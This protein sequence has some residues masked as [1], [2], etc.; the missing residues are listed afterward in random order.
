MQE[1]REGQLQE[2]QFPGADL[3]I[4][5]VLGIAQPGEFK[6]GF[7]S[8]PKALRPPRLLEIGDGFHIQVQIIRIENAL[9]Q[10]R[11]G[12]VR[13]AVVDGVQRIQGDEAGVRVVRDPVDHAVQ[14]AQVAAAPVVRGSDAVERQRDARGLAPVGQRGMRISACGRHDEAGF[15]PQI[16]QPD[17]H[18][19]IAERQSGRQ[20]DLL[21]HVA[22]PVQ[23]GRAALRIAAESEFQRVGRAALFA[24]FDARDFPAQLHGR[25]QRQLHSA[26]LADH[27][28][29]RG[30]A[31]PLLAVPRFNRGA[32]A[33]GGFG[34][35]PQPLQ[36]GPLG[37][38]R[39]EVLVA[40]D[41]PVFRVD[42]PQ[43]SGEIEQLRVVF[44][45]HVGIYIDFTGVP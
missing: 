8:R 18:I 12:V 43:A 36:N 5:H 20:R 4:F 7:R 30:Q 11:A 34:A 1:L 27:H 38:I 6:L 40:P 41:I 42:A 10:V 28:A 3:L 29:R 17:M 13:A 9:R 37:F 25:V 33:F 22:A 39:G 16:A 23:V 32:Q 31:R 26:V 21:A 24:N 45:L 19:V 15:L 35:H 44:R 2:A 14:I